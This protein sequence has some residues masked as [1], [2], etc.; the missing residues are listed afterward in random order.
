M[1]QTSKKMFSLG[2]FY[3]GAVDVIGMVVK[4]TE[5][6]K[7]KAAMLFLTLKLPDSTV[8][9]QMPLS[10]SPSFKKHILA[11]VDQALQLKRAKES[12]KTK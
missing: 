8:E 4:D 3:G 11:L 1:T 5:V 9:A 12:K 7:E 10:D 6:G 2:Q